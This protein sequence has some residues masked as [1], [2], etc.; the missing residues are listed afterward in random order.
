MARQRYKEA[1]EKAKIELS[2]SVETV[3]S[4]PFIGMNANG[5]INFE[6][7]LTRAKFEELTR[8]SLN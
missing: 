5:Q 4:L 7:T 8:D 3:I 2:S 6:A 1:A